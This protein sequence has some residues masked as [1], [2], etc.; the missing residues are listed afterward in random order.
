MS[1]EVEAHHDD[2][3][4]PLGVRWLCRDDHKAWHDAKGPGLVPPEDLKLFRQRAKRKQRK[5]QESVQD[6]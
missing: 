6:A 1:D 3:S 2:Y 5:R 4:K